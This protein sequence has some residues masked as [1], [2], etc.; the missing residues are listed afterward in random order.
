[1]RFG[2]LVATGLA[3]FLGACAGRDP[4]PVSSVQAQD[5]YSDCT[6]IRAEIEANNMRANQLADEEGLKV[7]QNVAAGVVGVVIWP[8]WFGMDFKDAAG[9]EVT[10]LQARQQFLTVLATDRCRQPAKSASR[11]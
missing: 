4:A 8:V 7:A 5:A 9:K 11:R 6:M 10:A 3:L 2:V 1:M